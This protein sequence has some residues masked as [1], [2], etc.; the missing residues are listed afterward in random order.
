MIKIILFL[1]ISTFLYGFTDNDFDGVDDSM[2]R[3]L[4]TPFKYVVDVDG[5][6]KDKT[7][8]GEINL[9]IQ[10]TLQTIENETYTLDSF[11]LDYNYNNYL[12]SISK[13]KY[14][15]QIDTTLS[16]GYM[17]SKD[18]I[19]MKI[20]LGLQDSLKREYFCSFGVD[21][22]KND[23]L[24]FGN[25]EYKNISKDISLLFGLTYFIKDYEFTL[26]YSDIYKDAD[27]E[28]LYNLNDMLYIKSGYSLSLND[29]SHSI[30]FSFGVSFE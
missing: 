23:F 30:Y 9:E 25:L 8:I 10:H 26:S 12:F 4:N 27:V 16:V 14:G 29:D 20:Y 6:P 1:T 22:F 18:D 2:D 7:Y 5:C 24:Y 11:Y 19:S 13:F 3:C 17:A 28:V 15:T 21:Y